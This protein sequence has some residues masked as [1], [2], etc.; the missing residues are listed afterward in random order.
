MKQRSTRRKWIKTGARGTQGGKT[1]AIQKSMI[2]L[3]KLHKTSDMQPRR[4]LLEHHQEE[5]QSVLLEREEG[6][7]VHYPTKNRVDDVHDGP[8]VI[9]AD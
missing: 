5:Q 3:T 2:S 4:G 8:S 9:E 1:Y 7:V 6:E